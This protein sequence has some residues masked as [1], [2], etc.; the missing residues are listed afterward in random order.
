MHK[1]VHHLS[2]ILKPSV[3]VFSANIYKEYIKNSSSSGGKDFF[4]VC[5]TIA[6]N[7]IEHCS[8]VTLN[9]GAVLSD[10]FSS[11]G[12][13]VA[14]IAFKSIHNYDTQIVKFFSENRE[15][16]RFYTNVALAASI[17]KVNTTEL[18]VKNAY[19]FLYSKTPVQSTV[20]KSFAIFLEKTLVSCNIQHKTSILRAYVKRSNCNE[21]EKSEQN[22]C[23]YE[24]FLEKD[25]KPFI[26]LS[27]KYKKEGGAHIVYSCINDSTDIVIKLFE[28]KYIANSPMFYIELFFYTKINNSAFAPQFYGVYLGDG[29]YG[30]CLEKLDC[31]LGTFAETCRDSHILTNLCKQMLICLEYI[32]QKGIVHCDV[33]PD[34]VLVKKVNDAYV[35]KICDFDLAEDVFFNNVYITDTE[36]SQGF[37][38]PLYRP[39][40]F[41]G[42]LSKFKPF[43]LNYVSDIWAYGISVLKIFRVPH[44]AFDF[45]SIYLNRL[46]LISIHNIH[47]EIPLK[48][49]LVAKL[50]LVNYNNRPNHPDILNIFNKNMPDKILRFPKKTIS[51]KPNTNIS[52]HVIIP[53]KSVYNVNLS[54]ANCTLESDLT[55]DVNLLTSNISLQ[56]ATHYMTLKNVK[57]EI[58][59]FLTNVFK[60]PDLHLYTEIKLLT[61]TVSYMLVLFEHHIKLTEHKIRC[62]INMI[63]YF[64]NTD[65][66]SYNSLRMQ[67]IGK[68]EEFNSSGLF[69]RYT[70]DEFEALRNKLIN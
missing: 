70:P 57:P 27:R 39:P 3:L 6:Y 17:E 23:S 25:V 29:C 58:K 68:L 60:L 11:E 33:K 21:I 47:C 49:Y 35:V 45:F 42:G 52:T 12:P 56:Q 66:K 50:C 5:V 4:L 64:A 34:N 40:E 24:S 10:K 8:T 44:D 69:S 7:I 28:Y 63:N 16:A 38:T 37:Y 53:P 26:D 30:I 2:K 59:S 15:R 61:S 48:V 62:F 22:T 13:L 51:I 14:C 67:F 9:N 65:L 20:S 19:D 46:G 18:D 36:K 43:S 54:P 1:T 41:A 31:D 55:S 32:N